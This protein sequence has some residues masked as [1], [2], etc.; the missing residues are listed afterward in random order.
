MT[1]KLLMAPIFLLIMSEA[2]I[3]MMTTYTSQDPILQKDM[4]ALHASH[5]NCFDVHG[6]WNF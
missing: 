2:Y 4:N 1:T 6:P 5:M 3:Y